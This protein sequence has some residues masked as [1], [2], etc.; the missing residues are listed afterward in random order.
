MAS[1][2][3]LELDFLTSIQAWQSLG[4]LDSLRVPRLELFRDDLVDAV[5]L[6]VG[7]DYLLV[8]YHQ[9]P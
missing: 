3:Q 5:A 7:R 1:Q 6:E 9:P 2:M 8:P 4:C